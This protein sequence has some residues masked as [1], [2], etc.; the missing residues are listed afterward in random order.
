[1]SE[2]EENKTKEVLEYLDLFGTKIG[3]YAEGKSNFYTALG[4][5]LSIVSILRSIVFLVFYSLDDLK[6]VSP[7]PNPHRLKK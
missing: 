7:I 4:G 3:F 6:R 1:M 5:V 2:V